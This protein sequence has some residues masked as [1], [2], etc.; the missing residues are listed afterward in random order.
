MDLIEAWLEPYLEYLDS[1]S[2]LTT[3]TEASEPNFDEE[4]PNLYFQNLLSPVHDLNLTA[5]IWSNY[6]ADADS[7]TG[8]T[9]TPQT[10]KDFVLRHLRESPVVSGDQ[11]ATLADACFKLGQH[12]AG[13]IAAAVSYL[14]GN[15]SIETLKLVAG[16]AVR[17]GR[18]PEARQAAEEAAALHPG[19]PEAACCLATTEIAAGD[20]K[21][22]ADLLRGAVSSA[23][24]FQPA[25]RLLL[26]VLLF[27]N[28]WPE[29]IRTGAEATE[30]FRLDPVLWELLSFAHERNG[31]RLGALKAIGRALECAGQSIGLDP[32]LGVRLQLTAARLEE[33]LGHSDSALRIYRGLLDA[34]HREASVFVNTA[35]CLQGR[36]QSSEAAEILRAGLR[37]HPAHADLATNLGEILFEAQQDDEAFRCLQTATETD[38]S[39]AGNLL[40]MGAICLRRRRFSEARQFAAAAAQ[41][42]PERAAEAFVLLG[43]ALRF[44]GAGGAALEAY[45]A[46]LD[47]APGNAEVAA[48]IEEMKKNVDSP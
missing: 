20:L 21:S 12:R 46:A 44:D 9:T 7:L 33:E 37:L 39:R 24:D 27:D 2:F 5:K 41:V 17:E 8:L 38:P 16:M 36:G 45:R 14:A 18:L 3:F 48:R 34:G 11:A 4:D 31:D 6:F 10:A 29:A 22:A 30:R 15:R 26:D 19:R 42:C 32:S 13:E 47:A 40:L 25:W 23:P 1:E 35:A 43:D 28:D